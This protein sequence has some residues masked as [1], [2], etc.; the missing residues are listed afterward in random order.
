MGVQAAD[1]A[2]KGEEKQEDIQTDFTIITMDN[3][4]GEGG[5]AVYKSS[6]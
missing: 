1:K 6:C 5:E 2:L 3:L 4:E